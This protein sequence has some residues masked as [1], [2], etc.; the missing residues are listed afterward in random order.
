MKHGRHFLVEQPAGS[1]MYSQSEWQTV[2]KQQQLFSVTFPQCATGLISPR[3][4]PI[5]KQTTLLASDE[6]LLSAFQGLACSCTTPHL[7]LAGS[8]D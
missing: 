5:Q 4:H 7:P 6:L 1:S 8:E 2:S 3:G